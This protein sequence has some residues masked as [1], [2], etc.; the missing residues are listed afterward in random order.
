MRVDF[1][2]LPR[3]M[4]WICAVC[5]LFLITNDSFA[6][7]LPDDNIEEAAPDSFLVMFDTSKGQFAVKAHRSW[8]PIAVDRFYHLIRLE[9]FDESSIYRMVQGFVAQFGIHN[10][11][12]VNEAWKNLGVEDEPV[13]ISNR[14]G[15]VSFARG[16]PKTRGTQLFIN[17]RDNSTLDT[18]PVG[19]V[20]GYPPIGVVISGMEVIDSFNAQ[21][22]NQPAMQQDSINVYGREFLDR[23]FPGLDFIKRVRLVKAY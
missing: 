15:T 2:S 12:E 11:E 21:Y 9:Y 23:R 3:C 8:S 14:R 22:G 16:G 7:Y 17:L 5:V 20:V 1:S 10:Q 6:Q 18:M 19:G 13:R 4:R